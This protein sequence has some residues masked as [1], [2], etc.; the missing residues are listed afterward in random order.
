LHSLNIRRTIGYLGL[1]RRIS[2]EMMK[3][4][5]DTAALR[6]SGHINRIDT[7]NIQKGLVSYF[8]W[9]AYSLTSRAFIRM[10]NGYFSALAPTPLTS[11]SLPTTEVLSVIIQKPKVAIRNMWPLA[12]I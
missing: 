8:H 11:I 6:T 10:G 7:F 5:S 4:I 1:A 2:T 9:T 3:Q 12:L